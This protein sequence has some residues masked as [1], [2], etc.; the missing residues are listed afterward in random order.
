MGIKKAAFLI[1]LDKYLAD[2]PFEP[3]V[4][5]DSYNQLAAENSKLKDQ[6]GYFAGENDRLEK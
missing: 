6:V 2:H 3:S 4:S 1:K 5:R